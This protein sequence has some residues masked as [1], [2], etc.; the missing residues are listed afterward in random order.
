MNYEKGSVVQLNENSDWCGCLGI[1]ASVPESDGV[2]EKE[3]NFKENL[4]LSHRDKD[5][6]RY[7]VGIPNTN[8]TVSYTFAE[9]SDFVVIGRACIELPPFADPPVESVQNVS[10]AVKGY[11]EDE[12]RR[13]QRGQEE[14]N[15]PQKC[16][17]LK[18]L[19]DEDVEVKY[20]CGPVADFLAGL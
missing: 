18:D 17:T 14:E 20:V 4:E 16:E 15:I 11:I 3:Q 19:A 5:K 6:E 7:I 10:P 2:Q 1:I 9:N 12:Y 8:G 13:E